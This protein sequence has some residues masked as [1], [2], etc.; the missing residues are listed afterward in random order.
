VY[1]SGFGTRSIDLAARIADGFITTSPSEEDLGRYRAQGG[2]GPAQG[3]MKVCWAPSA[4]AAVSTAHRL[5][6]TSGIPGEAAQE[7]RM[8]QHFEQISAI[9]T[10]DMTAS[11]VPCGPDP[12]RH[13]EEIRR[14]VDAG[15]DEVYIAQ[16]G[17]DQKGFLQFWEKELAPHLP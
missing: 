7:L 11:S 12:Q 4:E 16:M 15:F 17:P 5:W 10:E 2:R 3:G 8:P 9:V 14:Y 13:L 1:V 6:S